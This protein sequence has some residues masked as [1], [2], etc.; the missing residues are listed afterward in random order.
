[1]TV[2]VS[3]KTKSHH[4]ILLS[5]PVTWEHLMLLLA[6]I[7]IRLVCI[8]RFVSTYHFWL[9]KGYDSISVE[10]YVPFPWCNF[11]ICK[12]AT[13]TL[14]HLLFL[15][16]RNAKW[17]WMSI[18]HSGCCIFAYIRF[19]QLILVKKE[20]KTVFSKLYEAG[21]NFSACC[22]T[23]HDYTLR[24]YEAPCTKVGKYHI[25]VRKKIFRSISIWRRDM[26]TWKNGK[27]VYLYVASETESVSET[28]LLW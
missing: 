27:T 4:F 17:N 26:V 2:C 12:L 20:V 9:S 28:C 8:T 13:K 14:A 3:V 10:H 11:Q 1:M 24:P 23:D 7:S 15:P 22:H 19:R 21:E 16:L 18:Y 25:I 5:F 6:F